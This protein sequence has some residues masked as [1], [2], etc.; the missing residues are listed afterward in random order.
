MSFSEGFTSGFNMVDSAIQKRQANELKN[1]ELADQKARYANEVDLKNREMGLKAADDERRNQYQQDSLQVQRDQNT[2]NAAYQQGNLATNQQQVQNQGLYQQ[3]TLDVNRQQVGI[4]GMQ[5]QSA[6]QENAAQIAKI[7]IEAKRL[8][9]ESDLSTASPIVQGMLD[10]KTNLLTF[11]KDPNVF[12]SQKSALATVT[13]LPIDDMYN[14]P[15]AFDNHIKNIKDGLTDRPHWEQNKSSVID[16]LNST[17]GKDIEGGKVGQPYDGNDPAFKG[18]T[19]DNIKIIDVFPSPS[20]NGVIAGVETTYRLPNG[21]TVKDHGPM[22][23]LRSGNPETD[24]NIKVIPHAAIIGKLDAID[25][26]SKAI[27][28]DPAHVRTIQSMMAKK[29]DKGSEDK[30]FSLTNSTVD[31]A[32]GV[33]T[34]LQAEVNPKTG[35]AYSLGPNGK[36]AQDS[37]GLAGQANNQT[38]VPGQIKYDKDGNGWIL[39][40]NNNPVPATK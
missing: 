19:I 2:A 6:V 26:L 40:K 34:K 10:P 24:P 9:R 7:N 25:Q 27:N 8:K 21:E 5:A 18:S 37:V 12:N 13:N 30:T 36:V 38:N 35:K 28:S 20:G 17:M 11:S 29:D 15:V 31:P 33:E 39:D 32:T 14:N 1:Q 3:G 16:S 23:E 4:Q 22:T